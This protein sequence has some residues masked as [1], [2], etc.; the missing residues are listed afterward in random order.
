MRVSDAYHDNFREWLLQ[1][2]N[3]E[4]TNSDG[5]G[6]DTIEIP[7]EFVEHGSLLNTIF[8]PTLSPEQVHQFQHKAILCPKNEDVHK[9]NY[10]VLDRLQGISKTYSSV[11]SVVEQEN[12]NP[13]D[14]PVEFFNSLTPSG[15]PQHKLTLKKGA[16][17]M[18]MRNL[19]S[20]RGL[21]NGTRLIVH[22]MHNNF[23]IGKVLSGKAEGQIV[24][25]PRIDI[26]PTDTDLP[27]QLKRRQYP[28]MLAF[29]MT[30]TKSQG[31]SLEAVGIYL[32]APVFSHGQLYVAFSRGRFKDKIKV[33]VL[34]TPTQGCLI[35][36]SNRVFTKNIVY[37]KKCLIELPK[38]NTN[39]MTRQCWKHM[40]NLC[41]TKS[42]TI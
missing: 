18:L 15:T 6:E 35:E 8:G 19:N 31:Q 21:C 39:L 36:G 28:I 38:F 7:P 42:M 4:L 34:Q 40:M 26:I 24:F 33:K 37:T 10:I 20:T 14:Y 13:L 9:L 30:I 41:Y 17:I 3:G 29:V 12:I 27:F 32:S 2:G 5:L 25:I 16:I 11:D 23:I 1:L 22:A